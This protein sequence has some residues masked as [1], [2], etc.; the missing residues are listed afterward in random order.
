MS[1][2]YPFP[3]GNYFVICHFAIFLLLR[4]VGVTLYIFL[5][6][7]IRRDCSNSKWFFIV[8]IECQL[9]IKETLFHNIGI[10]YRQ[11]KNIIAALLS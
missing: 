10:K 3:L 11:K 8:Q 4:E 1:L 9:E 6:E 5:S 2:S 7:D